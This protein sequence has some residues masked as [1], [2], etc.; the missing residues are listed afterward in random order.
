MYANNGK[1]SNRQLFR[2]YVFD[3]I[4]IS[5]LLIPPILAKLSGID[6]IFAILIGG[7]MG[8][9]YLWYLGLVFKK[10]NTDLST[11]LNQN[12]F[13]WVRRMI[14]FY[15]FL[16]GVLTGGFIAYVF[17]NLMQYSLVREVP[18][19]LLLFVTIV[20]AAY[21]V[22][23]GVE[24][25]A[26]I[27][28]VL[29]WVILIPYVIMMIMGLKDIEVVYMNHFLE[30]ETMD[31][32]K[33]S[34]LVFVFLTPL[35]FI[36]F[37]AGKTTSTGKENYGLSLIK[38]LS[39]AVVAATVILLGSYVILYGNFGKK[40]LET[41]KFPVITLM[42]TVQLK[43]NFLKR[44][45]ALM[46]AVWF[47]TLL[48]LLNLHIHFGVKGLNK[49]AVNKRKW[50]VLIVSAAVFGVAFFYKTVSFGTS[51]F[52]NYYGYVAI[53][54][55]IVGPGLL[56][57]I[58]NKKNTI[59]IR[60]NIVILLVCFLATGLIGCQATQLENRCFP[61]MV[62]VDYDK[63][64]KQI[65]YYENFSDTK[66]N[67]KDGGSINEM[68]SPVATGKDFAEGMANFEMTLSK[69]PDYNHL[70]VIV[71]GETLM[72]QEEAYHDMLQTLIGWE[73][74]PRNTYVCVT[75]D[76]MNMIGLKD[77]LPQELGTLME[78]YLENHEEENIPILSLGDMMDEEANQEMILY[79]PYLTAEGDHIKWQ[80]NYEIR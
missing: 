17:A 14:S 9:G 62:A 8:L 79:A 19:I 10:M 46:L 34:G 70:K 63:E 28:E 59:G 51:F 48:A 54:I 68:K 12:C 78:E 53:P 13:T 27:Y 6:G 41:M 73:T 61:M 47:F 11:Y 49:M 64:N 23:G 60:Q 16:H 21:S 66:E 80:G 25:R 18:Y 24:N 31:L 69:V 36:L 74:F 40:A 57:L 52:L 7:G 15:L 5:T 65:L 77:S 45:D 50:A 29:F 42:S 33:S 1:I 39:K 2:L 71:I 37:L 22:S 44:M 58:A 55:M 26:R 72:E 76:I 32:L 38:T 3:L 43:G 75:E 4:G 30:S 67:S 56:L 20:V 35:C